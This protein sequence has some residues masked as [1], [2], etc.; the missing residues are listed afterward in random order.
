MLLDRIV[1]HSKVLERVFGIFLYH[2]ALFFVHTIVY[3][4]SKVRNIC[5]VSEKSDFIDF[6][7][8]VLSTVF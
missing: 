7:L 8:Y 1:L 2:K 3:K 5:K 4:V 6:R